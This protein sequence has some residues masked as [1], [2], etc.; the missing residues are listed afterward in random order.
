MS[1]HP[2][3]CR[4]V[5][6]ASRA[7][8][9]LPVN[10]P[11]SAVFD[12]IRPCVRAEAGL[13]SII[14]PDALDA[15][16]SQSVGLAPDVFESWLCTPP[17]MLRVTLAPVVT[18]PAG[19]LWRDSETV[20]GPQREQ[21]EV[22]SKLDGAGLGEGAGYK[23]LERTTP[24]HGVEHVMLAL[25]M[26]RGSRVP[27]HAQAMLA[28]LHTS[29][30]G[31]VLRLALPLLSH[32]PLHTQIVAEQTLG[33]ICVS[34]RGSV[35]EANRRARQFVERYAGVANIVGRRRAV[36]EFARRAREFA[37]DGQSWRLETETSIL[38]VAA[39][40]LDKETHTIPENV[41]LLHMR[42]MAAP[43]LSEEARRA[44]ASLTPMQLEIALLYARTGGADKEIADR[45][46]LS[47]N[48]VRTHMQNIR[49]RLGVGTRGE[50]AARIMGRSGA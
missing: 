31:A 19:R 38:E 9:K 50:I 16:V 6:I 45:L 46:S 36:E 20:R 26:K 25:L 13:Y 30:R 7:L 48:T 35:I 47:P 2:E 28:A 44:R 23:I 42:E 10:A 37:R 15:L 14:R 29:I 49:Q 1:L 5:E 8:K 18:S 11:A 41:V 12:A 33:Y 27:E 43:P 34:S 22:L 40:Q 24:W 39:H 3:E 32:Q 4:Q 17:E 21:L